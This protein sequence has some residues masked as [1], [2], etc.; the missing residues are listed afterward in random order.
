MTSTDGPLLPPPRRPG[1]YRIGLVC[2]GNICRSPMAEVVLRDRVDAAGLAPYVV[3]DSCGTAGWHEGKPMDPRSAATLRAAGLDP[4]RHR[5]QQLTPE[6]FGDHDLHMKQV[7]PDVLLVENG[8]GAFAYT[9]FLMCRRKFAPRARAVFFTW[10]NLPYRARAPL[11][12]LEQW[13]LRPSVT[14]PL[15]ATYR[16]P[17]VHSRES[18][19]T[20]VISTSEEPTTRACG[21]SSMSFESFTGSPPQKYGR[22][23]SAEDRGDCRRRT[24]RH[25][26]IATNKPVAGDLMKRRAVPEKCG[27]PDRE[28]GANAGN[29]VP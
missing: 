23:L 11:H 26:D 29:P 18:S 28:R 24:A 2:L 6:W 5:A 19:T 1:R 27:S 9:Q 4:S 13:N 7:Q 25:R 22:F 16:H 12:Q 10:W 15:R 14:A 17:A 20:D 21:R 8:A 3:V